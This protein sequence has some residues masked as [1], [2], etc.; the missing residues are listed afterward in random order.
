M[1][2]LVCPQ[3]LVAMIKNGIAKLDQGSALDDVMSASRWR[4]YWMADSKMLMITPLFS[5]SF[6]L[7]IFTP[8]EF[9]SDLSSSPYDVGEYDVALG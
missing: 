8:K 6:D 3:N 9:S 1:P 2:Q 7:D 5:N 4:K